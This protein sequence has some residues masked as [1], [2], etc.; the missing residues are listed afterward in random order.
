MGKL[1]KDD[2]KHKLENGAMLEFCTD[3][4]KE[5][6]MLYIAISIVP[7]SYRPEETS[8]KY[9]IEIVDRDGESFT[10][11]D[12]ECYSW[13]NV[14]SD[15]NDELSGRINDLYFTNEFEIKLSLI[16]F[17]EKLGEHND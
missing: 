2:F 10:L 8:F 6:K 14:I 13:S 12:D 5:D 7:D 15:L 1:L 17:L 9:A 11:F 4:D 3:Y 16:E